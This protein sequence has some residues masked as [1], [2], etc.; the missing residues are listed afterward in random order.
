MTE[1][2]LILLKVTVVFW[3]RPVQRKA[4]G[5]EVTGG[6]PGLPVEDDEQDRVYEG[7]NKCNV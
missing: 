3:L 4:A 5:E 2:E 1:L 7:V 6:V